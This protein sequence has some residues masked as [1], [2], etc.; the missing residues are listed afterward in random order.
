MKNIQETIVFLSSIYVASPPARVVYIVRDL[1][2]L[3]ALYLLYLI[4]LPSYLIL[5][6]F[7]MQWSGAVSMHHPRLDLM[8]V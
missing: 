1:D 7:K 4:L 3:L 5:Q 6:L 8:W 2:L